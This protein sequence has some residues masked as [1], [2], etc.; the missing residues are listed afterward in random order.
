MNP[1]H[2]RKYEAEKSYERIRKKARRKS[3]QEENATVGVGSTN[4]YFQIS[5][6]KK[7]ATDSAIDTGP[8]ERP[9]E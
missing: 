4:R 7:N 6:K 9:A 5:P 3:T 8:S 1:A 2:V